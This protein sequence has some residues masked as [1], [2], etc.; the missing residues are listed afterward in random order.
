MVFIA[1]SQELKDEG[2]RL[3]QKR[4]H[5]GAMVKYEK[6]VALLPRNHI[7]VS[8]LRSNIA[9]CYMQMGLGEYPRAIHE[10]NLAHECNS[11]TRSLEINL[12]CSMNL[13]HLDS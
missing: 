11:T 12:F 9:A 1:M 7:D 4:D 3:F 10:C 5:E 8:C 13:T 6:A 2:N